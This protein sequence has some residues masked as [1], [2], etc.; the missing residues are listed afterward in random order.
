MEDFS[1]SSYLFFQVRAETENIQTSGFVL[2]KSHLKIKSA[3]EIIKPD[4]LGT[5]TRSKP[6]PLQVG[7][8]GLFYPQ[9]NS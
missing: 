9:M 3:F 2:A 7:V 4:G 6:E 8:S 5:Q 1:K